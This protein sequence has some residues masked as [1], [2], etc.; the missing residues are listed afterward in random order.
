ML[1]GPLSYFAFL[2]AAISKIRA[3]EVHPD[4]EALRCWKSG[5]FPTAERVLP[6]RWGST[7]RVIALEKWQ[8]DMDFPA[9]RSLAELKSAVLAFWDFATHQR[10]NLQFLL[11]GAD[12]LGADYMPILPRF[13]F[14]CRFPQI[15]IAEVQWEA[16]INVHSRFGGY[17]VR[18]E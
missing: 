14:K 3:D 12:L 9:V 16:E 7:T 15:I 2:R 6:E 18:L 5:Q 1:D 11:A 17:R 13:K 4:K 10:D 8:Q